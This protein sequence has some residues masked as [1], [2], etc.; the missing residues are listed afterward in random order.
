MDWS[1]WARHCPGGVL[2]SALVGNRPDSRPG[3]RACRQLARFPSWNSR[4]SASWARGWA[5]GRAAR[6][7]GARIPGRGCRA[8]AIP[9]RHTDRPSRQAPTR[10]NS[11]TRNAA[12]SD[13]SHFPEAQRRPEKGGAGVGANCIRQPRRAGASGV[14][15]R[16]AS[17][18]SPRR[19]G[20]LRIPQGRQRS[21][22]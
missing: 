15:A 14:S 6:R 9:R 13:K 21:R 8:R 18:R 7:R 3:I 20:W 2:E 10:A 11:R 22:S 4:L 16:S 5:A 12:N 19:A 1:S 17:W